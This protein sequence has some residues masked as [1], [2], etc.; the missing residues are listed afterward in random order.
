MARKT[1]N[2]TLISLVFVFGIVLTLIFVILQTNI[3]YKNYDFTKIITFQPEFESDSGYLTI[4]RN[5]KTP[6]VADWVSF[7]NNQ[8]YKFFSEDSIIEKIQI[9]LPNN[10]EPGKYYFNIDS[11]FIES[12]KTTKIYSFRVI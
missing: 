7:D 11:N 8:S 6:N 9:D 3:I 2:I 12:K 10:I 1:K 5:S 4:N